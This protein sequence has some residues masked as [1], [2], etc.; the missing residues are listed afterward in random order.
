MLKTDTL[1]NVVDFVE[2]EREL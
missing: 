2:A 1:Q